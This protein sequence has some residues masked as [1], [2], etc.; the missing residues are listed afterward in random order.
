MDRHQWRRGKC[1]KPVTNQIKHLE[2][3]VGKRKNS[4][5]YIRSF[6]E[7][8]TGNI[9]IGTIAH[10]VIV[11]NPETEKYV[12]YNKADH[13]LGSDAIFSTFGDSK[14]NIWVGTMGGGLSLFNPRKITLSGTPKAR[15]LPTTL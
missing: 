2:L 11:Y 1:I 4:A 12:A 15:A 5:N 13:N 6:Y 10:G 14:G 3:K 9:W 7:D 8:K